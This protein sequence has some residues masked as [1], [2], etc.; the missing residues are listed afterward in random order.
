MPTSEL[1]LKRLYKKFNALY[2]SNELPDSVSIFYSP[3]SAYAA[4]DFIDGVFRIRVNPVVASWTGVLHLTILHELIHIKLWPSRIHGKRFDD[5]VK[6]LMT[7]K[8][9]RKLV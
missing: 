7:F 2:F 5:E 1:Q 4:C 9:I 6:R 8:S 3:V